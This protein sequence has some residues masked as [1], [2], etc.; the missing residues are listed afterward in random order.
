MVGETEVEW[1]DPR[2][3]TP[4]TQHARQT[5]VGNSDFLALVR[6]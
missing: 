1:P 4:T 6:R 5:L 3:V 2:Q